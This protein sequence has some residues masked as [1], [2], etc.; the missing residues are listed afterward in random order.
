MHGQSANCVHFLGETMHVL[1]PRCSRVLYGACFTNTET[2]IALHDWALV[3]SIQ[4]FTSTKEAV[5]SRFMFSTA[6]TVSMRLS[7]VEPNVTATPRASLPLPPGCCAASAPLTHCFHALSRASSA[8]ATDKCTCYE[9]STM[10][11]DPTPAIVT[12]FLR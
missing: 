7:R 5:H 1:K 12:G 11:L 3:H 4:T 9:H 8:V 6:S 10:L 2:R